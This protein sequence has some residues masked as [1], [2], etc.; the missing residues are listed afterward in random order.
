MKDGISNEQGP[1]AYYNAPDR[2]PQDGTA[3]VD[4]DPGEPVL[5]VERVLLQDEVN[6][7]IS[8]VRKA[9]RSRASESTAEIAKAA[10]ARGLA[11]GQR[12]GSLMQGGAEGGKNNV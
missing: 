9:E 7:I 8:K 10:Y 4:K 5:N 2:T 3:V 12:T 1:S 11:A 6:Q